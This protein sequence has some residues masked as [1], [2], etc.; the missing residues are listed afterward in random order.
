[1]PDLGTLQRLANHDI[2]QRLFDPP[3]KPKPVAPPKPPPNIKLLGTIINATKS[4][5]MIVG[6]GG[7]VEL[8]RVGDIVGEANN[9]AKILHIHADHI[10]VEHE[11]EEIDIPIVENTGRSR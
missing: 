10:T 8:K 11:G 3:P 5:A 1:M 4:Q 6:Q 9:T 7:Q 2:R